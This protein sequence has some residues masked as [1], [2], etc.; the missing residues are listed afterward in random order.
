MRPTRWPFFYG[1]VIV[2]VAFIGSGIGSGVAIWGASVF[3]LP[4][5]EEF[6]WSRTAFFSAF[7]V[8]AVLVGLSAPVIGPFLDTRHGPR[9]LGIAGAIVLGTSMMGLRYV[10]SLWQFILLYGVAG[11]LAELGSGFT[12]STTV[13]PKWFVRRRGRALG[14]A[15]MGVG[16]GALVF[17][18]SVS[19]L[20]NAVGW[21]DAWVWF[22][23]V[24]GG[25]SLLLALLV[26]TRPEDVGLL[27]DGDEPGIAATAGGAG[28]GPERPPERSLTRGEALRTPAFW[29]LLASFALV[30]LGITGFQSNWLPF[31]LEGGFSS[32]EASGAIA[33]YGLVSGLSRPGWGLLGERISPRWLFA[34][35]T[36]ATAGVILWFLNLESVGVLSFAM[37]IA[38]VTMG[39]YI[40]LRALLSANYFGRAYLGAVSSMFRPFVMG[41]A[42]I[43]PLLFGVLYDLR[44]DYLLAF[45]MAAVAWFSA[46]LV[47][48]LARPPSVVD[49]LPRSGTTG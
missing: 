44:G 34:A 24:T 35:S 17:P 39:G 27:P 16:L 28:D 42:S 9:L 41:T 2:G 43:G 5:T 31:L 3:V 15:T 4:M 45:L 12:V 46:G 38:G 32:V 13:V 10:D 29:M 19:L 25:I 30:G 37:G 7:T 20:V 36:M 33:V 40:I 23:A 48:L 22:G 1:W 14:I 21:R 18:G 6:G 8:R 11:A 47:I 49:R 26:R